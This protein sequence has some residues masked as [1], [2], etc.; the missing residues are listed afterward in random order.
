MSSYYTPPTSSGIL[1]EFLYDG[2]YSAPTSSGVIFSF[3]GDFVRSEYSLSA[4]VRPININQIYSDNMY[5]YAAFSTELRIYEIVSEEYI[6]YIPYPNEINTVWCNEDH[7]FIGT[8]NDGIKY[9][10]KTCISGSVISPYDLSHCISGFNELTDQ[11]E[12]TS[13][14]IKHI[15][16]YGDVL[17]IVTESGVDVVKL[18]NQGY[19]SSTTISGIE[20][21]FMTSAGKF[22][23]FNPTTIYRVDSSLCDWVITDKEYVTGSGIFRGWV[24]I[25]DIFITEK[26][27]Y[28]NVSNTIFAATTQGAYIIDEGTEDFAIYFIER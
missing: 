5:L 16:G 22:Y 1:F 4:S 26:T 9:I 25:K 3:G 11:Y 2:V 8:L 6:A 28:D 10:E 18:G 19:R 14:N 17:L 27:S 15:H 13:D 21:G 23:Y 12:L 24:E 7:V 20:K